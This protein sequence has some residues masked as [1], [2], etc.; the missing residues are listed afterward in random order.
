MK[1]VI[2]AGGTGSR[3]LPAT[4]VTNKHLLP[5]YNKPMILYPLD[6]LKKMGIN[7][8]LIISGKEHVGH[9][10]GLLGS[11]RQFGL[12]LSYKVQDEAGGIAQALGLAEDF[13]KDDKVTVILGDN[14]FE[15]TFEVS[16]FGEGA[17]IFIKTVPDPERF[18]VAEFSED[19][20]I[21]VEEKPLAPKT[22]YAVTGLYVYD[23]RV[24][25]FI[26]NLKPS[27]RGE[28]E[29]TD[30]NNFYIKSGKMDYKVVQGF[31]SDAGTFESLFRSSEYIKRKSDSDKNL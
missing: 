24:F 8:M 17:R 9:I 16:D 4:Q 15:D 29:L 14:I 20:I 6:T 27:A 2:L 22:N 21:G 18:G 7:D 31:W 25:D 11:G 12:N 3:M 30:V 13:A 26:K 19:K 28:L 10:I 23:N 5:I 1:G